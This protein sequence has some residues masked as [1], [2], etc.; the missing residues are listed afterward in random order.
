MKQL[1]FATTALTLVLLALPAA[2]V[3]RGDPVAGE[4]KAQACLACHSANSV[5]SNPQ[6]PRLMGQHSDY[7]IRVLQAYQS[8]DRRNAIM[9]GQASGLSRQDMR[10]LAAWFSSQDGELY[11]PERR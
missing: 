3:E 10:D 7:I 9:N 11:T 1:V 6:W 4:Q 8:G 5:D 2:A